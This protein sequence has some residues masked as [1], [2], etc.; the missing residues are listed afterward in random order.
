MVVPVRIYGE[1]GKALIDIGA[2]KCFVTMSCITA[3]G[4]KGIPHDIFLELGNGG[5]Y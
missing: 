1:T 3:V 5:K 2:T 4:L